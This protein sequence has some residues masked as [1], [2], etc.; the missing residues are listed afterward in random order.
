M[1][2]GIW[3][4]LGNQVGWSPGDKEVGRKRWTFGRRW[5]T[6]A[7]FGN[8]L[9]EPTTRAHSLDYKLIIVMRTAAGVYCVAGGRN[10]AVLLSVDSIAAMLSRRQCL[11]SFIS[12]YP[13]LLTL[14]H[15]H[16]APYIDLI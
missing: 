4:Q 11:V 10:E 15:L 9:V 2:L 5:H 7:W 13:L 12:A 14:H 8:F 3:G 16:L 6:C 1:F